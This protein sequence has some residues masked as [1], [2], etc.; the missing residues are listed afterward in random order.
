MAKCIIISGIDGSG[1]S[2]IINETQMALE[3]EGKKVGYIWLRYSVRSI[4][5]LPIWILG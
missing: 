2:T 3:A 5:L 4:F 1:K